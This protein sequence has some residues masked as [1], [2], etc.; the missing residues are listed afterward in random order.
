MLAIVDIAVGPQPPVFIVETS[1]LAN[2]PI[3]IEAHAEL[4]WE[5]PEP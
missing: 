2:L 3:G 1:P 4:P 5:S